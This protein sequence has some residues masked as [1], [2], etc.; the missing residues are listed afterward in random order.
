MKNFNPSAF[1]IIF[2]F[3]AFYLIWNDFEIPF[4]PFTKTKE[5]NATIVDTKMVPGNGSSRLLQKITYF[6][7]VDGVRY[8]DSKKIGNNFG[9]QFKGNRVL[10]KYKLNNPNKTKLIGVY[11]DFNGET[12]KSFFHHK[13]NG[14]LQITLTNNL[15]QEDIYGQKGILTNSY[16]GSFIKRN[17]TLIFDYFDEG[18][19][20]K[21]FLQTNYDVYDS[22]LIDLENGLKYKE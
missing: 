11:N 14:M 3:V 6:Y 19:L 20:N 16:E 10:I 22:T 5:I 13:E 2:F 7:Y 1:A 9:Y 8:S 18:I 4:S 12:V 21:K 15:F 17:D